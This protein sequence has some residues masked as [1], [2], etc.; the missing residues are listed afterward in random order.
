MSHTPKVIGAFTKEQRCGRS[1]VFEPE[2]LEV[3]LGEARQASQFLGSL[4]SVLALSAARISEIIAVKW[5]NVQ[6]NEL[7]LE[8]LQ[9]SSSARTAA[10]SM[11]MDVLRGWREA[12]SR[13]QQVSQDVFVFKGTKLGPTS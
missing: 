3:I 8:P 11:L 4:F 9:N 13:L 6:A 7:V 12:Q 1:C 10:C 5:K 2:Q